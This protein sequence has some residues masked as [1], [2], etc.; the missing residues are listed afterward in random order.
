MNAVLFVTASILLRVTPSVYTT[1]IETV[2]EIMLIWNRCQK[3]SILKAMRF[4]LSC[5][6]RNRIDLN[7][8]TILVRNLHCSIENSEFST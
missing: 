2:V 6:Q 8:V 1:P 3:W 5:K 4:Y 7:T